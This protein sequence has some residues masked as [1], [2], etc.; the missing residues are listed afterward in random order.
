MPLP[1]ELQQGIEQELRAR[2]LD[3]ASDGVDVVLVLVLVSPFA[4]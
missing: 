3:L 1:P 4:G 2:L